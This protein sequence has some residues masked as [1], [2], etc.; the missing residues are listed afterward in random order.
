M[1]S[2]SGVYGGIFFLASCK[3]TSRHRWDRDSSVLHS[4]LYTKRPTLIICTFQHKR[5]CFKVRLI[6]GTWN[7]KACKSQPY[8]KLRKEGKKIKVE[9]FCIN[10]FTTWELL[11]TLTLFKPNVHVL[12]FYFLFS[13]GGCVCRRFSL[14]LL[15][16]SSLL[17]NE[18][19]SNTQSFEPEF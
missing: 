13:F 8:Y 10:L 18:R 6:C 1:A 11:A 14:S 5:E 12:A 19:I 15:R 16:Y 4:S 3:N 7:I 2:G 9:G 17:S